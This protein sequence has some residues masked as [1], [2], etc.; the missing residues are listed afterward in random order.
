MELIISLFCIIGVGI[1]SWKIGAKAGADI[2][3]AL[4]HENKI[5]SF[6][7]ENGEKVIPY[8]PEK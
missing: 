1:T 3:L 6:E 7:D 4:L 8:K 2:T 5:I